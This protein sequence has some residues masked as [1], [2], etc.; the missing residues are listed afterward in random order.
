MRSG[1]HFYANRDL[2]STVAS[3]RWSEAILATPNRF[4]GL[5]GAKTVETVGGE[6]TSLGSPG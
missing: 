2:I 1:Q 5:R 3:A 6:N 4:N